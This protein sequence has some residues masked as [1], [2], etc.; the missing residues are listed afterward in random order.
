MKTDVNVRRVLFYG[1]SFV[2]GK[3]SGE[4][5][6]LDAK[7]RFTGVLQDILGD[8]YDILE[9]GLR[10]GNLAG[11]NPFFPDRDRSQQ[12]HP[13]ILSQLPVDLVVIFL[14]T[15]DCNA[16]NKEP[17]AIAEQLK[18]YPPLLQKAADFLQVPVPKLLIAAP[19]AI[20]ET[21]FDEAM[22]KLF[23]TGSAARVAALPALFERV[24]SELHTAFLNAAEFCRPAPGD[25][26]HL[27]AQNNRALAQAFADKI[28]EVIES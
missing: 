6:R 18:L 28:K 25:G 13:I 4:P 5:K 7:T 24:A 19:P 12:F 11:E 21:H 9:E 1:D 22:Q 20:D 23:G 8:Q 17:A 15:N 3:V 26:L 10:G 2:F 16:V 27:D 14:G